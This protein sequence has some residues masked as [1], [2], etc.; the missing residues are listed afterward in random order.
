[1]TNGSKAEPCPSL[2]AFVALPLSESTI[3]QLALQQTLLSAAATRQATRLRLVPT[4][5]FH[6]T[7]AF[8]GSI[9]RSQV[10][11]I[12]RTVNSVSSQFAAFRLTAK[13]LLIFP[14]VRRARVISVALENSDAT[15]L[16]AVTALHES[17]RELGFALENRTFRAHVTLARLPL[18][19]G[20]L[21]EPTDIGSSVQP[22]TCARIVV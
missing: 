10:D 11:L 6:V 16:R 20:I 8:L 15:L 2:R 4:H 1:M 13:E 12:I 5:H 9:A 7:L 14:S 19:G 3:R 21:L 17:F 22:I 18:N